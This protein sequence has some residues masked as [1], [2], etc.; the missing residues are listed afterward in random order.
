MDRFY[1]GPE[2]WTFTLRRSSAFVGIMFGHECFWIENMY[3]C[4]NTAIYICI[5]IYYVVAECSRVLQ[6]NAHAFSLNMIRGDEILIRNHIF[7][8]DPNSDFLRRF[9]QAQ[10]QKYHTTHWY[11]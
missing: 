11:H 6:E 1:L 5:H 4:M 3:E 9:F 8:R 10:F 2:L 7:R